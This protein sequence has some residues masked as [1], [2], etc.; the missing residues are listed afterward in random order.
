[1]KYSESFHGLDTA[2]CNFLYEN[3]TMHV[4]GLMS[5]CFQHIVPDCLLKER[6]DLD[7]L[8][9][10]GIIHSKQTFQQKYVKVKTKL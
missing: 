5:L 2:L 4:V 1:M 3:I 6:L 10:M 8:E 7:T 9:T